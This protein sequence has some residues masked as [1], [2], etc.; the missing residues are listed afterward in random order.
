MLVGQTRANLFRYLQDHKWRQIQ[1][2]RERKLSGSWK[3]VLIKS[4]ILVIPTYTMSCFLL[5]RGLINQMEHA[6]R[7]FLW[8]KAPAKSQ[9]VSGLGF[10][11]L[12]CF[13]LE[14]LAK[15]DWHLLTFSGSLLTQL[16]KDCY[17]PYSSFMDADLGR[18]PLAIWRSILQACL[19]KQKGLHKRIGDGTEMGI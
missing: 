4:V 8:G 1:W 16:L 19:Y 18:R 12:H 3:V 5:L 2:W 15:Q 17:F 7:F 9:C 11:Y 13:N 10:R 14:L 6:I